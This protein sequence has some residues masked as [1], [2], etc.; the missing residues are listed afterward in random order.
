MVE[1]TDRRTSDRRRARRK[2]VRT[3]PPALRLAG[4]GGEPG[5]DGELSAAEL[6]ALAR[7]ARQDAARPDAAGRA[8]PG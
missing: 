1:P 3:V 2:H 7:A 4:S 8:E 5:R 6:I